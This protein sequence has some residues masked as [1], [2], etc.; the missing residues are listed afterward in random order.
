MQSQIRGSIWITQGGVVGMG[1]DPPTTREKS[2]HGL[3]VDIH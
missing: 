2:G 3:I 1:H